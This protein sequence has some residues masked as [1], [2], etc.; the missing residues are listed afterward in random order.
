MNL[1]FLKYFYDTGKMQSVAKSAALNFVSAPAISNGI[2]KLEQD[3]GKELLNHGR[4][5]I[6]L[7]KEGI[8]LLKSCEDIFRLLEETKK[9]I[10]TGSVQKS[11]LVNVGLTNGLTQEFWPGF[12]AEFSLEFPEYQ[13]SFK[14]GSPGQLKS[15]VQDKEIDFALTISREEPKNYEFLSLYQGK[16][17]LI[18]S[19]SFKKT[20]EEAGFIFTNHWPEVE[21]FKK[22]YFKK[23]KKMPIVKYEVE[24][25]GTIKNFVKKGLGIGLVP[26]YQLFSYSQEIKEYK[27][28]I[29]LKDYQIL[30]LFLKGTYL[31]EG[32]FKLVKAFEAYLKQTRKRN[33]KKR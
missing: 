29:E 15:W 23:Y 7:T 20:T 4:N 27:T 32:A 30:A 6:E 2:K 9:E 33:L 19:S 10:R 26:D 11:F 5:K 12:L 1:T 17:R 16:F 8:A 24:S 13:I 22:A 3:L 31:N 21:S 25:W 18:T 28:S 14:T